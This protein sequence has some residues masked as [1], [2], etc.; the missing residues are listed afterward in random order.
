MKIVLFVKRKAKVLWFEIG[1]VVR[2]LERVM[3]ES[4]AR[5]CPS[6]EI[7]ALERRKVRREEKREDGGEGEGEDRRR[8]IGGLHRAEMEDPLSKVIK[9]ASPIASRS[10]NHQLCAVNGQ[11]Y[12]SSSLI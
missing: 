7:K 9:L 8:G 4:M 11:L 10:R 1:G 3:V 6:L 12:N 2:F 5:S